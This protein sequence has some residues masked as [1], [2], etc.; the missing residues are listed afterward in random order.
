M[1]EVLK[2][3]DAAYYKRTKKTPSSSGCMDAFTVAY[4]KEK[5]SSG[6]LQWKERSTE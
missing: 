5:K 6:L 4:E 2:D 3:N 1:E